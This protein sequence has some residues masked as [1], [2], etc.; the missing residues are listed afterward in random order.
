[1]G[2]FIWC[3]TFIQRSSYISAI[4]ETSVRVRS[5][6]LRKFA[7]DPKSVWNLHYRVD[8]RQ[9]LRTGECSKWFVNSQPPWLRCYRGN[10]EYLQMPSSSPAQFHSVSLLCRL[11][12]LRLISVSS[13]LLPPRHII[14]SVVLTLMTSQACQHSRKVRE[15]MNVTIID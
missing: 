2:P 13:N 9:L 8:C 11:F 15:R 4:N 1:M 12:S 3:S 14:Q 10:A 6:S 5:G 7:L